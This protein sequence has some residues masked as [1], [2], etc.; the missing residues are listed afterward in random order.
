MKKVLLAG[1][2]AV[3]VFAGS[4]LALEV[5]EEPN[6]RITKDIFFVLD[7]S[8]SMHR[9]KL[10]KAMQA[11]SD[12]ACQETD[13]LN[14]AACAF[15]GKVTRWDGVAEKDARRNGWAKMP[16]KETKDNLETWLK[17]LNASGNTAV[18]PALREALAEVSPSKEKK[19][20]VVLVTDGEFDEGAD[21]VIAEISKLQAIRARPVGGAGAGA[22]LD[23]GG[24]AVI[25]CYGIDSF[26]D[27]VD[28]L[29]LVA[30]AVKQDNMLGG[31]FAETTGPLDGPH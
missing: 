12:I 10:A 9:H 7:I 26:G 30:K 23:R 6:A 31:Y 13:D 15:A 16:S 11:I 14:I 29:R 25:V 5:V 4:A 28:K 19:M 1:L 3:V 27:D 18:L 24:K 17:D 21:V 20:T 2:A 22:G 8:G